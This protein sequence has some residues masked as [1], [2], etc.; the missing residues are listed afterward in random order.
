MNTISDSKSTS[1]LAL[2]IGVGLFGVSLLWWFFYYAQYSG[3]F[4]LLDL[5]IMCINGATDECAF[6][7]E[8]MAATS[9]IP[10]YRPYLWYAG[11]LLTLL[12]FVQMRRAV[13]QPQS[14]SSP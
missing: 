6:F 10:T 12:G 4:G 8:R 5:K 14:P 7:Q 9:V 13:K 2:K 1:P 11:M 3:P